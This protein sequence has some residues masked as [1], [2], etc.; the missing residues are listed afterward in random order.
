MDAG[1]FR[2]NWDSDSGEWIPFSKTTLR[3]NEDDLI[4]L[5]LVQNWVDSIATYED[6]T[7]YDWEYTEDT[8]VF[9]VKLYDQVIGEMLNFLRTTTYY[10]TI[11]NTEEQPTAEWPLYVYPNPNKGTFTVD[12][13]NTSLQQS[14][15]LQLRCT[16]L[17]GRTIM[18]ADVEPAGS[19]VEVSL[20][21]V[22]TGTY[23]LYLTDGRQLWQQKLVIQQ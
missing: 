5:F 7:R 11:V 9:S 23:L 16:D 22:P 19:T 2:E 3:T 12:L 21:N 15:S 17:Q 18:M 13:S 4:V 8:R 1:N 20:P 14:A 6:R 10:T